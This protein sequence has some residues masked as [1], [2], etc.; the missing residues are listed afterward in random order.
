M[1]YEQENP[2][3]LYILLQPWELGG[4]KTNSDIY[5]FGN[6]LQIDYLLRCI[7]DHLVGYVFVGRSYCKHG[8]G[9]NTICKNAMLGLRRT[10]QGITYV[11]MI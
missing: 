1:L 10:G 7:K 4:I 8:K 11:W 5:N 2:N 6:H 3:E 9:K